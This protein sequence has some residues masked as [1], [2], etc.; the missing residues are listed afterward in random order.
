MAAAVLDE[1]SVSEEV[2][3]SVFNPEHGKEDM[4]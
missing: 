1:I 3:S 4:K 2:S